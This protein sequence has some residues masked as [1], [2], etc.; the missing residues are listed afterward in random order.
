MDLLLEREQETLDRVVYLRLVWPFQ[1]LKMEELALLA[2]AG[3]HSVSQ[4]NI[5]MFTTKILQYSFK[6]NASENFFT[7][8]AGA[9]GTGQ[10]TSF[11]KK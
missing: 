10:G 11:G 8:Q 4:F 1:A 6:P 7:G 2:E 9:T 5:T 3:V